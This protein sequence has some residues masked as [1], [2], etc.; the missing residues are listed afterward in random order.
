[1]ARGA[2]A[3]R[4]IHHA[5]AP[6]GGED[7]LVARHDPVAADPVVPRESDKG[8]EE[9]YD[10]RNEAHQFEHPPGST[11]QQESEELGRESEYEGEMIP[12][13]EVTAAEA[14]RFGFGFVVVHIFFVV[15]VL[16]L[17][18]GSDLFSQC[19]RRG[20]EGRQKRRRRAVVVDHRQDRILLRR[21]DGAR[22]GGL[23]VAVAV[24][25]CSDV[26]VA[27]AV[28]VGRI[29]IRR[30]VLPLLLPR[31]RMS[32][33]HV[34]G[35]SCVFRVLSL[36]FFFAYRSLSLF[37]GVYIYE[38][39]RRVRFRA[40]SVRYV[41]ISRSIGF[42]GERRTLVSIVYIYS[43]PPAGGFRRGPCALLRGVR[44]EADACFLLLPAPP[45]LEPWPVAARRICSFG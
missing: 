44:S 40:S 26:A 15:I 35:R 28:A 42:L 34:S 9:T 33:R 10:E 45:P 14:V 29:I 2:P 38:I 17:G 43:A 23:L 1:M 7:A 27:V 3:R 25:A 18:P 31:G 5:A 16:V 39:R 12:E 41:R 30:R 19:L 13:G 32:R 21:G 37:S 11:A 6:D 8:G 36:F 20:K 24:A 4:P 22:G